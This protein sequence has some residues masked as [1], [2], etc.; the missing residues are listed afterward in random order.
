MKRYTHDEL[1]GVLHLHAVLGAAH[2]SNNQQET[3]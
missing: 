1:Q 2:E 3:K